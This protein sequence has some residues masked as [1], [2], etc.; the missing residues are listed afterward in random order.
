[1]I[2]PA[3][4]N[5]IQ[6]FHSIHKHS[7]YWQPD[8]EKWK[9]QRW[10]KQ[11]STSASQSV[12][13]KEALIEPYPGSFLPFADGERQCPGKKFAQVELVGAVS[14]LFANGWRVVP[15][16]ESSTESKEGARA[17]VEE[18][19]LDSGMVL[20]IEMLHPDRLGLRWVE[21]NSTK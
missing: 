7:R 18:T 1:M 4:T 15:V 16:P 5:I 13:D 17:R 9:P 20:L 10:I 12:F 11:D 6:T 3:D 2:L 14:S 8:P 19:I 21:Q